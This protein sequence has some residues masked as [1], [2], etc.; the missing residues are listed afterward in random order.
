MFRA[1]RRYSVVLLSLLSLFVLVGSPGP[2]PADEKVSSTPKAIYII[3]HGEKPDG[4]K[5]PNLAPKGYER[6]KALVHVI[7]QHFVTPDF[8]WATAPTKKSRRPLETIQPLAESLH[9]T[10]QD[11]YSDEQ[12]ADLAQTLLSDSKYAGKNIVIAWHHG[13]IPNLAK[14]LGAK[15]AP[16]K[17]NG[18]VFD[19]VWVLTYTDGQVQFQNL[20]QM[21]LPGDS[22]N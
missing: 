18:E 17:W 21:A 1:A 7:P 14:A 19:R 16:D 13:E 3:R 8:I 2:I 22:Q 5:D 15:D 12:F 9:L 10:V 20:P 11:K 4:E 6:A